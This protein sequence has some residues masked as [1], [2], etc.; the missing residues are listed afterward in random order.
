MVVEHLVGIG[1]R[2][3]IVRTA[4]LLIELGLRLQLVGLG[5][6]S[7]FDCRPSINPSA[8]STPTEAPQALNAT[9]G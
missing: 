2:S 7:G 5:Y 1:W 4:H 6:E 3:A 8:P 9:R